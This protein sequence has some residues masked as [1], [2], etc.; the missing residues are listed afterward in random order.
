MLALLN[1]RAVGPE[2]NPVF[3][4][5]SFD[6]VMYIGLTLFLCF[7]FPT[8]AAEKQ[9][10][11]ESESLSPNE[12]L[13]PHPL[14][15]KGLV[16][17]KSDGT[18]VYQTETSPQDRASSLRFG[19]Y[20]PTELANPDTQVS[21]SS[22]YSDSYM[23]MI[24]YDYEWQF[25]RGALGK[26]G[27]KLGTG[28]YVANGNG[29]FKSAE[30]QN[31]VP[32]ESFTFISLPNSIAAIYRL[33]LWSSQPVVPFVEGGGDA[34]T[35]AEIRD[36]SKSPKFGLATA[37]HVAAGASI[38]LGML[39]RHSIITLDREFGINEVWLTLEYRV[40]VAL[41]KKFDFSGQFLNGGVMVEF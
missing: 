23:P 6:S 15:D 2:N 1:M 10:P 11:Q 21:F 27:W 13:I 37:A 25:W 33:Q 24:L 34:I 14:A 18:Y 36:D 41:G 3:A 8:L 12:K 19:M 4:W 35:F 40:L 5:S 17:I 22:L 7:H 29:S 28:I 9:V 30:N 20:D 31:L 26:L 39:D 32:R 16:R 38:N